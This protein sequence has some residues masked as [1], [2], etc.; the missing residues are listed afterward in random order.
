MRPPSAEHPTC[1]AHAGCGSRARAPLAAGLRV[2]RRRASA[3]AVPHALPAA[4]AARL[5]EPRRGIQPSSVAGPC[6]CPSA[7][8]ARAM[9]SQPG[10]RR[11]QPQL[12]RQRRQRAQQPARGA[13]PAARRGAAPSSSGSSTGSAAM[14]K[15]PR[16][17]L[18]RRRAGRRRRRRRRGRPGHRSR[19][20]ARHDA[21]PGSRRTSERGRN[22]PANSRRISL[23][24]SRWKISPGRRRTNRVSGWCCLEAVE[25]RFDGSLV[26][27]VEARRHARRRPAL[28]D[29]RGPWGPARRPRPT[30]RRPRRGPPRPQPP[31]RP[32]RCRS[33]W[34]R[35]VTCLVARRLDQPREVDHGV[36]ATKERHEVVTR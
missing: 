1:D 6:S 7:G 13:A 29:E 33:R 15:A 9:S 12:P 28:V 18:Q 34:W 27:G 3:R 30:R 10:S 21:A 24:A 26:A 22:G 23:A 31:R 2:E 32:G 36:G 25:D 5:P 11:L 17:S 35:S 16:T 20:D 4:P 19:V 8:T 14:L